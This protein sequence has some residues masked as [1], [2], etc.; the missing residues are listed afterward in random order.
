LRRAGWYA[1]DGLHWLAPKRFRTMS[2]D[3]TGV[4]R[5]LVQARGE[6]LSP[7]SHG[8]P[9][10]DFPD[11]AAAIER[12]AALIAADTFPARDGSAAL[13]RIADIAFVLHERDVERSLCDSLDA[14]VRDLAKA[15]KLREANVERAK[16]ALE[17][18][19]EVVRRIEAPIGTK[20]VEEG[21]EHEL[22]FTNDAT[23][24]GAA[25]LSMTNRDTVESTTGDDGLFS[26]SAREDEIFAD[27]TPS[28]PV[29]GSAEA[30]HLPP[31]AQS[32][33]AA[34]VATPQELPDPDEDPGDLFEPRTND[35][36]ASTQP[37]TLAAA[38]AAPAQLAAAVRP[39]ST[40]GPVPPPSP[41]P[42]RVPAVAT[43][44]QA[45][46]IPSPAH[47]DPLAPLRALSEEELIALFS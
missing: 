45:P 30:A 46:A 27:A 21:T 22:S 13:E 19:R 10:L 32:G 33:A 28:L 12:V 5:G 3:S 4:A 17:S 29:T 35:A 26:I 1:V 36:A 47:D 2:T 34:S 38:P 20:S 39:N 24:E 25:A 40:S 41:P 6:K 37:T 42:A 14:A 11:L 9:L 7:Q 43:A 23:Q 44:V 15:H 8:V 16:N 31:Q 18:L